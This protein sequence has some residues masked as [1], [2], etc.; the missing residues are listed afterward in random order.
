[1]T[2]ADGN[3]QR[4]TDMNKRDRNKQKWTKTDSNK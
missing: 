1:M 3:G 2:E 4:Q